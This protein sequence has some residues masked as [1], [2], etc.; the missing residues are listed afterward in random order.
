MKSYNVKSNAKRFARG[1]AAK[2]EGY[3]EAIEPVEVTPGAR[4]WFPAVMLVME[5]AEAFISDDI[6]S[7]AKIMLPS[8]E[9]YGEAPAEPVGEDRTFA[10]K[11]I[12]GG[13]KMT[14]PAEPLVFSPE[15]IASRPEL[16]EA[17]KELG[18]P[19]PNMMDLKDDTKKPTLAEMAAAIPPTPARTREEIDAARAERRARIEKEK[20]EGIRNRHGE[21]AAP[22]K[23]ISKKKIILDLIQRE[24][25]AT[26][27]E[28]EGATGWQR[29]TLR[30]YIAGTLRKLMAPLGKVIEC[31]RGSGEV[32]TRYY[33]TDA[34]KEG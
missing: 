8:G 24:Q 11:W 28:L 15:T 6:A 3:F 14:P 13:A 33:L 19:V 32:P 4:E 26:Q 25:G 20:A 23:K 21:R 7:T 31:E 12:D 10:T 9:F 17:A 27:A 16:K 1:I 29:H 22:A 18:I 5:S 2:S 34:K 30:G